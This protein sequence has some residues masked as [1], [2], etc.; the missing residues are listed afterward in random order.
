M[1]TKDFLN[2]AMR[3]YEENRSLSRIGFFSYTLDYLS[4]TTRLYYRLRTFIRTDLAALQPHEQLTHPQIERLR[5]IL[6]QNYIGM[7]SLNNEI[8]HLHDTI[9][10]QLLD[11]ESDDEY[12]QYTDMTNILMQAIL[13]REPQMMFFLTNNSQ[14]INSHAEPE[15]DSSHAS[16]PAA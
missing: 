7:N 5:S 14:L 10:R 16:A 6:A 11:D 15:S 1:I 3:T 12:L 13:L 8:C 9:S 4:S 2:Q